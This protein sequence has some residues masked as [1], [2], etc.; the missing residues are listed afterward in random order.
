MSPSHLPLLNQ[1][2]QAAGV[3]VQPPVPNPLAP[4]LLPPKQGAKTSKSSRNAPSKAELEKQLL[5]QQQQL[6]HLNAVYAQYFQGLSQ[7][8]P[9][10]LRGSL[11][12]EGLVPLPATSVPYGPLAEMQRQLFLAQNEKLKHSEQ[13]K[14]T[15]Q[16]SR[17][18]KGAGSAFTPVTPKQKTLNG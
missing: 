17:T 14:A 6:L 10:E 12:P 7:S 3:P 1:L 16:L 8:V 5:L 15:E 9:P 2:Q 4:H 18:F 11:T 13:Q